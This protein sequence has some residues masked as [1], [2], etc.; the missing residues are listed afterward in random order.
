VKRALPPA[1]VLAVL[2]LPLGGCHILQKDTYWDDMKEQMLGSPAPVEESENRLFLG[3]RLSEE[4][5]PNALGAPVLHVFGSSPAARAGIEAGDE[6]RAVGIGTLAYETVRTAN[7][8]RTLILDA[9]HHRVPEIRLVYARGGQ[10]HELHFALTWWTDYLKERR[11]RVF[12][13]A[14]YGGTSLPFFFNFVTRDLTPDFVKT[15]F[16]ATVTEPVRVYEDLDIF[17][18]YVTGISVYRRETLD[19]LDGSRTQFICWPLRISTLG[20]D[21]TGDLKNIIPEGQKGVADL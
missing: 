13:E 3:T 20:E 16:G 17:P 15:Y 18:L 5:D 6:I 19:I 21:R 2:L 9:T 7:D 4:V 8:L 11:K 14:S 12:S 10:E 1:L